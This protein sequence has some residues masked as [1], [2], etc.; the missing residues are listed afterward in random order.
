MMSALGH[1]RT[2]KH[3]R[4]MSALPPKADIDNTMVELQRRRLSIPPY[5]SLGLNF[6]G[7][8]ADPHDGHA[9]QQ[10]SLAMEHQNTVFI[11]APRQ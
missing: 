6:S 10:R 3:V 1:K 5:P 11:S 2:S 9:H 8:R 4:I 7:P